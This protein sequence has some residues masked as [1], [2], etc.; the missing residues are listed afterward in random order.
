MDTIVK[1]LVHEKD[2]SYVIPAVLCGSCLLTRLHC[3]RYLKK[4]LLPAG[5]LALLIQSRRNADSLLNVF[6]KAVQ[7]APKSVGD[8]LGAMLGYALFKL[9]STL[10][11]TDFSTLKKSIMDIGYGLVRDLPMVKR[12]LDKE[13]KTLEES[14]DKELKTKSRSYGQV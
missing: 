2:P 12:E 9:G 5:I 11:S 14:M 4:L 6:T 13:K 1:K 3:F 7:N 10:L 8:L